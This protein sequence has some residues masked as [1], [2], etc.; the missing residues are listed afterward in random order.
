MASGHITAQIKIPPSSAIADSRNKSKESGEYSSSAVIGRLASDADLLR[1]VFDKM[2]SFACALPKQF[3]Q[4]AIFI[5]YRAEL[6]VS[7][8]LHISQFI[9]CHFFSHLSKSL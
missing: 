9:M 6:S 1:A 7:S 4:W 3:L 8:H 5:S 2:Y